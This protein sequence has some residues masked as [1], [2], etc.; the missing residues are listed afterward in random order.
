MFIKKIQLSGCVQT[1]C[2]VHR[3]L[4]YLVTVTP[5]YISKFPKFWLFT[6]F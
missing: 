3:G 1:P 5:E 4:S 6:V 2:S